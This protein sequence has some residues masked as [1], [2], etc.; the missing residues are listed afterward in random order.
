MLHGALVAAADFRSREGYLVAPPLSRAAMRR[1]ID[2]ARAA[3]RKVAFPLSDAF[4]IDRHGDDFRALIAERLFDILFANEVAICAHAAEAGF[5][6]AV[7]TVEPQVV[8]LFVPR[9]DH[10]AHAAD[11]GDTR[12]GRVGPKHGDPGLTH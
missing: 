12:S 5:D 10:G 3:G 1:A 9:I 8:L 2:V 6:V 7:A 4:I 11:G